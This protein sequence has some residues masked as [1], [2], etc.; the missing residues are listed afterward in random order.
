MYKDFMNF[1][2]TGVIS[3]SF[4]FISFHVLEARVTC[5]CFQGLPVHEI[6]A[7][8]KTSRFDGAQIVERL[9]SGIVYNRNERIFV[10]K[11]LSKYLMFNCAV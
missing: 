1:N 8:C 5:S 10:V 4:Q 11:T 7:K 9:K 6:L 2:H 3:L